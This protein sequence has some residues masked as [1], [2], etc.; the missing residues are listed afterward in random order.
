MTS[1]IMDDILKPLLFRKFVERES[2][3]SFLGGGGGSDG[4]DLA[5]NCMIHY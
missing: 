1:Y 3:T 2:L 5:L 4:L